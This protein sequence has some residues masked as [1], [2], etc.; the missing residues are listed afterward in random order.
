VDIFRRLDADD[1]NGYRK[2]TEYVRKSAAD[3]NQVAQE[4]G[5]AAV[6]AFLE[7]GPPNVTSK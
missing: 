3:G 7:F 5:L 6:V 2:Y 1:A 4:Q